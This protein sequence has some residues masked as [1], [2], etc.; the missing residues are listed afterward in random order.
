MSRTSARRRSL[1]CVDQP[2]LPQDEFREATA[3]KHR[4]C[5]TAAVCAGAAPFSSCDFRVSLGFCCCCTCSIP[6]Q[7]CAQACGWNKV[8]FLPC[9]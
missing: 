7:G 5:A 3:R 9:S 8:I 1:G 6:L 2:S 4:P